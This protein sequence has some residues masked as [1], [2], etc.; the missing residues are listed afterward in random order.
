VPVDSVS[1][2]GTLDRAI[3]AALDLSRNGLVLTP[4]TQPEV[5]S[6]RRWLCR[7]VLRQA[8][9]SGPE[10]WAVPDES[11][12]PPVEIEDWH[13]AWLADADKAL[14]AANDASQ[15]I[16]I[17]P[18]AARILGYGDDGAALIG[19]RLIAIIPERYRQAHVA[20]FTMF[21]LVGRRPLLDNEVVVPALRRDGTEVE[22]ALLVR[23]QTV[24]GRLMLIGEI[25][26]TVS[27]A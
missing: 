6:F 15:I 25:S 2:F 18:L 16:G 5:Q 10:P 13:P 22:I 12:G 7:Q 9:G 23:E 27:P 8:E 11:P 1:H 20:G 24:D 19:E 26:E 4:P 3:E 17:S 21:L 14:I